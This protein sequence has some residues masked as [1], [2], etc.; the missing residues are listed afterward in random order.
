MTNNRQDGRREVDNTAVQA[1]GGN[2]RQVLL[3]LLLLPL[4]TTASITSTAPI[5]TSDT[6]YFTSTAPPPA[7]AER[8]H[9]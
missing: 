4:Q 6:A 3:I 5:S 1:D 9:V 2:D 8:G 7:S